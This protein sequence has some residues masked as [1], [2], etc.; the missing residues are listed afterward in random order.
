MVRG[1]TTALLAISVL[2]PVI[3]PGG[4]A[5]K[6]PDVIRVGGPSAPADAKVAIVATSAKSDGKP[7]TVVDAGDQVVASGTLRRFVGAATPWHHGSRA[8]L[9]AV[10]APGSYRVKYGSLT[11]PPWV[12]SAAG[13]DDAIDTMLGFFA[14]NSDGNEPSPIHGP[15]HLND[16]VVASG[17][18]SGTQIDLTGGWMDAGDMIHFT[19]TTGFSAALLQAAARLDPAKQAQLNATADVGVRWLLKAHPAPGVFIGQVGDERDHERGFSDPALDDSSGLAGIAV[20]SA[21][22]STGS[23]LAGK[24]AAAL[25]LAADRAAGPQRA[26]LLAAAEDWYASGKAAQQVAALPGGFYDSNTWRD[27]MAAGAAAL[28]RTTGTASYLSDALDYLS[29]SELEGGLDWDSFGPF[30]AADICG[31]LGA[32]A[33][34]NSAQR[35]QACA[36]LALAG[37]AAGYQAGRNP[38]GLAGAVAWGTTAENGGGGAIAAL[39]GDAGLLA[40]GRTVAARARDYTIGLNPWGSSLIAGYGPNSPVNIHSWASTFGPALPDGAV[41]GGPA[42]KR[43]LSS[44]RIHL[45]KPASPF[46]SSKGVYEDRVEDYVTS[47]PALDYAAATILLQAAL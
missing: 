28:A 27:D 13:A 4:A 12:V 14:A 1:R 24:A 25:A 29:G 46:N 40:G 16:A 10:T 32:P 9:S 7:F 42:S 41:V 20:R 47:E 43:S 34:G 18:L 30:A 37:E 31:A 3:A 23:D 38:F 45:A 36:A 8:D 17:P 15:S 22:P 39:A 44:E 2:V 26:T 35:A 5:A 11:S 21:Y 6:V 33:L 19:Q